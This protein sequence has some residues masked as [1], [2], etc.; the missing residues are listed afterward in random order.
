MGTGVMV[1]HEDHCCSLYI[2]L[3][4]QSTNTLSLSNHDC[5]CSLHSIPGSDIQ[6]ACVLPYSDNSFQRLQAL[7][8]G[9][10]RQ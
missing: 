4:W 7:Q 5:T 10:I 6:V 1:A 2:S 9:D 3:L 8:D